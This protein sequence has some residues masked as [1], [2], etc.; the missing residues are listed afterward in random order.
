MGLDLWTQRGQR[1]TASPHWLDELEGRICTTCMQ[2]GRLQ[3]Q[4]WFS[5]I[6]P[7]C[8][9]S[10]W[11]LFIVLPQEQINKYWPSL[12]VREKAFTPV[13]QR[14]SSE[15]LPAGKQQVRGGAHGRT[16]VCSIPHSFSNWVLN[17]R[18]IC[19]CSGWMFYPAVFRQRAD[20]G[21]EW[22]MSNSRQSSEWRR[23]DIH[24]NGPILTCM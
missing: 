19:G 9:E 20:N 17:I 16:F 12:L 14:K 21:T 7:F 11:V 23:M 4:R 1:N 22:I 10:I 13:N 6:F 8:Y 15:T 2:H 24:V 3:R 18:I 5:Q